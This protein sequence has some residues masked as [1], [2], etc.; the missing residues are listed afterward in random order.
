MLCL[1]KHSVLLFSFFSLVYHVY[2]WWQRYIDCKF[3]FSAGACLYDIT[4]SPCLL[5]LPYNCVLWAWHLISLLI[6]WNHFYSAWHSGQEGLGAFQ[7]LPLPFHSFLPFQTHV[8]LFPNPTRWDTFVKGSA[9]TPGVL[10]GIFVVVVLYVKPMLSITVE[11][12]CGRF[13]KG[14]ALEP[15]WVCHSNWNTWPS[16]LRYSLSVTYL[17][18][19]WIWSLCTLRYFLPCHWTTVEHHHL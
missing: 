4:L 13:W 7:I 18:D 10:I 6:G 16:T 12:S 3:S 9:Y 14:T 17:C 15:E 11:S 8:C 2:L 1:P 19:I 5:T